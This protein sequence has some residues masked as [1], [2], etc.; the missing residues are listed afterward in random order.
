MP[1]VNYGVNL[2]A[3]A[4]RLEREGKT[5]EAAALL[6]EAIRNYQ[7][8]AQY[9]PIDGRPWYPLANAPAQKRETLAGPSVHI[10]KRPSTCRSRTCRS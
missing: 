4:E 8:A 7:E 5:A 2:Q 3:R 9:R 10:A 1:R 6:D